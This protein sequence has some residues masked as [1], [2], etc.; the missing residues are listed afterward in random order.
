MAALEM[1]R[2]NFNRLFL[3]EI[4][5]VTLLAGA[6]VRLVYL[7]VREWEFIV[8]LRERTTQV[9]LVGSLAGIDSAGRRIDVESADSAGALLFVVRAGHM[10]T[11]VRYWNTVVRRIGPAAKLAYWGICDS[12]LR[13]DEG[14]PD[15][16]FVL[17]SHLDPY[18]MRISATAHAQGEVLLYEASGVLKDRLTP[19]G[20]PGVFAEMVRSHGR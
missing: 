8:R 7:D 18:Q 6:V 12:G 17:V 16:E 5:S 1:G 10:A 11:D 19:H 14:Q 9:P 15:A 20:D 13:C 4:L 2:L 3:L